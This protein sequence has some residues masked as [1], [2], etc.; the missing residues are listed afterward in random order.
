[1]E[2]LPVKQMDFKLFKADYSEFRGDVGT[3]LDEIIAKLDAFDM[4]FVVNGD[5]TGKEVGYRR[6]DFF[7]IL[8]DNGVKKTKTLE[9]IF[10]KEI[11]GLRAAME[12]HIDTGFKSGINRLSWWGTKLVPIVI[13]GGLVIS[14][15]LILIGQHELAQEVQRLT[16]KN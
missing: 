15:I 10:T 2:D 1:M 6:Q 11:A 3:K 13:L 14:L 9:G 7:Q 5:I 8:Y 4:I 12:K 16:K